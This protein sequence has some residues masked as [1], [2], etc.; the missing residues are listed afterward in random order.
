MNSEN[1]SKN[2]KKK[3]PFYSFFYNFCY[4]FVRLTGAIPMYI[5]LRPKIYHPYKT[6][7]PKGKMLV[8]ANHRSFLDPVL[9]HIAIPTRR[10]HSLA[11]DNLFDTKLKSAFFSKMHCIKVDKENFSLSS[12]H[13]V[14]SRLQDDKAVIIFPEGSISRDDNDLVRTFKSG[15]VLMAHRAGAPIVPMYIPKHQKWYH[16][17]RVIV[18]KP[19]DVRAELGKMPTLEQLNNASETLRKIEVELREYYENLPVHKK[20]SK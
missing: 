5:F 4:D 11:T 14:I 10:M 16:R 7:T 13:T 8:S 3:R 20:I 1:N 2:Q 6:K 15:A 18:G 19:F 17:Y 12:M 9:V